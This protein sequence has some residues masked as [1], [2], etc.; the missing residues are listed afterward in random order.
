VRAA[1]D[2]TIELS[3]DSCNQYNPSD[4]NDFFN[5]WIL[6]EVT[7]I[8]NLTGMSNPSTA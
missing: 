3:N 1:D 2:S 8:W 6:A 5:D 4:N 7:D